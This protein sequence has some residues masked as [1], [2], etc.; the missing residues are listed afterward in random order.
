MTISAT[1]HVDQHTGD[2]STVDFAITF[3]LDQNDDV[4]VWELLD[5]E[6]DSTQLVELTAFTLN[7]TRDT[8]TF[9]TAPAVDT[10]ITFERF[11]MR[12][13]ESDY[14][15]LRRLPAETHELFL[16]K[17]TMMIQELANRE[18]DLVI[19][20]PT[21]P[22]DPNS[23]VINRHA[24]C[25]TAEILTEASAGVYT[26]Q[27]V[28]G[29]L[30]TFTG[31]KT[32][33]TARSTGGCEN[34]V[35]GSFVKMVGLVDSAAGLSYRFLLGG[36][37]DTVVTQGTVDDGMVGC[38]TGACAVGSTIDLT[39]SVDSN[40]CTECKP[41]GG[42]A[43]WIAYNRTIATYTSKNI[44]GADGV[45]SLPIISTSA[46]ECVYG[47]IHEPGGSDKIAEVNGYTADACAFPGDWGGVS[48]LPSLAIRV[49]VEIL[50]GAIN[51]IY[52]VS[53]DA[54]FGITHVWFLAEAPG[55]FLCETVADEDESPT[56]SPRT[57]TTDPLGDKPS[58]FGAGDYY[59]GAQGGTA[60][61]V[62]VSP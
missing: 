4:R 55:K 30:A 46:S 42:G 26:W 16:D 53:T 57:C 20:D 27:E 19:T 50:T 47:L 13:Q 24:H 8:V 10:T 11:T 60:T 15:A 36:E 31:A 17:P 61:A 5:G 52:A 1:N 32:G 12:D 34:V 39:L 41:I 21:N 43:S 18:E 3:R 28:D 23:S 49:H 14:A 33:S 59:K 62:L 58:V 35:I 44:V 22:G 45:Y 25:F 51:L 9:T 56:T 29:G 38:P 2:A 7:A 37:C 40:I 54:G 48:Y 6:T